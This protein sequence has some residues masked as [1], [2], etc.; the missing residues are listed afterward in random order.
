MSIRQH[1]CSVRCGHSVAT[2]HENRKTT[3]AAGPGET[4]RIRELFT[5]PILRISVWSH[6]SKAQY[7]DTKVCNE[8]CQMYISYCLSVLKIIKPLTFGA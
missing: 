4:K 3:V 2:E 6:Y 1:N 7:N 8:L 5:S